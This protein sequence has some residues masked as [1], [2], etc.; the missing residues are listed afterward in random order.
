[1]ATYSGTEQDSILYNINENLGNIIVSSNMKETLIAN[2]I[3]IDKSEAAR[4]FQKI[5][6][7]TLNIK[8]QTIEESGRFIIKLTNNQFQ[9]ATN[10]PCT[11]VTNENFQSVVIQRQDLQYTVKNDLIEILF[12]NQPII[13][14]RAFNFQ[15]FTI[16]SKS[17]GNSGFIVYLMEPY[18]NQVLEKGTVSTDTLQTNVILLDT[19]NVSVQLS[20]GM[21]AQQ[22]IQLYKSLLQYTVY[23]TICINFQVLKNTPDVD[24]ILYIEIGTGYFTV[25]ENNNGNFGGVLLGDNN[26]KGYRIL[27]SPKIYSAQGNSKCLTSYDQIKLLDKCVV[28]S[29]QQSNYN[30]GN[31]YTEIIMKGNYL[32]FQKYEDSKMALAVTDFIIS[33]FAQ[34]SGQFIYDFFVSTYSGGLNE[35]NQ[36]ESQIVERYL[37]NA[38]KYDGFINNINT[39][40]FPQKEILNSSFELNGVT[41]GQKV[42]NFKIQ[43][44]INY[45]ILIGHLILVTQWQFNEQFQTIILMPNN[46][47]CFQLSFISNEVKINAI[48]CEIEQTQQFD[49]SNSY[50]QISYVTI[51]YVYG[52][53]LPRTSLSISD[54]KGIEEPIKKRN[55]PEL[56]LDEIELLFYKKEELLQY[57]IVKDE[58]LEINQSPKVM[59]FYNMISSNN[60]TFT[61]SDFY[62]LTFTFPENTPEKAILIDWYNKQIEGRQ[63]NTK[64]FDYYAVN[65]I[66]VSVQPDLQQDQTVLISMGQNWVSLQ[67]IKLTIN[68][69]V[70]IMTDNPGN[71]YD[72]FY[73]I[74]G[75]DPSDNMDFMPNAK[76][77]AK[78]IFEY[79]DQGKK[80]RLDIRDCFQMMGE[81]YT[82][83]QQKQPQTNDDAKGYFQ[84]LDRNNDGQVTLQDLENVCVQYLCGLGYQQQNIKI[85][86]NQ[87]KQYTKEIE[88]RLNV[89]RKIFKQFDFDQNGFLNKQ[90]IGNLIK[91]TYEQIDM[92]N[93]TPTNQEIEEFIKMADL[94][95]QRTISLQE[96][97]YLIVMSLRKNGFRIENEQLVI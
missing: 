95:K 5:N 24:S 31:G 30:Q 59:R 14:S 94:D 18:V 32:N 93:V 82:P 44:K 1:M 79:F 84:V 16:N 35:K 7:I 89:A 67:D 60:Q 86:D 72:I 74:T 71:P 81:A 53:T 23:N 12:I 41:L 36:D 9:F 58:E 2:V 68:G 42:E 27:T 96:Y 87:P 88:A 17:A 47:Q 38:S 65:D 29:V 46:I 85:N 73:V 21:P 33:G 61:Q 78:N 75:D 11:S 43:T 34:N 15:F 54:D 37:I 51:P 3:N 66:K 50:L 55:S 76:A 48:I 77:V 10:K 63:Q 40:Y 26:D 92:K 70:W 19:D 6:Q 83:F 49:F 8:T 56:S 28:Q 13:E 20:F 25:L 91:K 62:N 80:G 90:E 39:S 69:F 22:P 45:K 57:I 4:E 97:E 52:V 64:L